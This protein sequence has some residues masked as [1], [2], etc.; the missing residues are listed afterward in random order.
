MA[1]FRD[2]YLRDIVRTY[3]YSK[4]DVAPNHA[5]RLQEQGNREMTSAC[6]HTSSRRA[7]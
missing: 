2:S 6:G 5:R 3:G 4:R 1:D 7:G